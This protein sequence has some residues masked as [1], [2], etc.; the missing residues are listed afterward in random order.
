[1]NRA[2]TLAVLLFG[3]TILGVAVQGDDLGRLR[4][5]V[6]IERGLLISPV[7]TTVTRRN[8][9]LVGLGSY[10]VNAQGACNDC[11]TC[12][13][14]SV[15]P[16]LK[17]RKGAVNATN[18]LA[19][20]VDFMTPGGTFTSPNLTPD[21]SKGNLPDGGHTLEQFKFMMRTGHDV[22]PPND[23]LQVMPWPIYGNM[24]DDDLQAVYEY[25][26]SIPHAEPGT[27]GGGRCP[28]PGLATPPQQ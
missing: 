5:D 11:H 21:P 15:D 18:F 24:T 23:I 13:S 7:Q 14:Y 6:R 19:G 28:A 26:K 17:P 16:Y 3:S 10:I 4:E 2:G 8:R 22:D 12:P 1:M 27:L 9:D 20:G 25:L